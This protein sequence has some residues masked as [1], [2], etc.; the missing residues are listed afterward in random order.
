MCK[1]SWFLA[2]QRAALYI[3]KSQ[4]E[5]QQEEEQEQPLWGSPGKSS[6]ETSQGQETAGEDQGRS[7]EAQGSESRLPSSWQHF[8]SSD[9][10]W[11]AFEHWVFLFLYMSTINQTIPARCYA[12][13]ADLA[14]GKVACSY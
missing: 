4:E 2:A 13:I 5:Q 8:E 7:G 3:T 6:L 1:H 11:A 14:I 12:N 9:H 10:F